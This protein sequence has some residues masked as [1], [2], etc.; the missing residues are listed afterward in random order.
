[1]L[2]LNIS[3]FSLSDTSLTVNFQCLSFR[4][5]LFTNWNTCTALTKYFTWSRLSTIVLKSVWSESCKTY[6]WMSL[7][8]F[9]DFPIPH[10]P[11]IQTIIIK[12]IITVF[13]QWNWLYIRQ[14]K[15]KTHVCCN[16]I[17]CYQVFRVCACI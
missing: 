3:T 4:L 17:K 5:I 11:C 10:L 14:K 8:L 9:G 7:N 12:K 2:Y 15:K 6:S 13:Y 16:K 1:M